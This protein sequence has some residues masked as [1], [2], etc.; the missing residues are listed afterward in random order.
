MRAVAL[1]HPH[2]VIVEAP[3]EFWDWLVELADA[4]SRG[5]RRAIERQDLALALLLDLYDLRFPPGH[6]AETSTTRR[7]RQLERHPT[8]RLDARGELGAVRF[9]VAFPVGT[10]TALVT[11]RHGNAARI[12]DLFPRTY[13]GRA[14]GLVEHWLRDRAR[15]ATTVAPGLTRG[16][17]SGDEHLAFG[18]AQWGVASRVAVVHQRLRPFAASA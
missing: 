10:C 12:G 8:W 11:S 2:I 14:H 13:V 7:V 6:E 4:A 3:A 5:D 18:L 16:F 15:G 9:L 1:A 17:E